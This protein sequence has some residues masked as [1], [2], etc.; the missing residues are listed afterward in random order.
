[1]K[2]DI[3]LEE[4]EIKD[5]DSMWSS[6]V[7]EGDMYSDTFNCEIFNKIDNFAEDDD[8]ISLYSSTRRKD[9]KGWKNIK[10]L[11]NKSKSISVLG[12]QPLHVE[13]LKSIVLKKKIE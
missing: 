2:N 4:Y 8:N 6:D 7:S 13:F 11:F 1:M 10:K 5:N 9:T 12:S 3:C